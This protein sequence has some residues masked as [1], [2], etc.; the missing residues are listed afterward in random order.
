MLPCA[1]FFLLSLVHSSYGRD[2]ADD[3]EAINLINKYFNT[4]DH[5]NPPLYLCNEAQSF[6]YRLPKQL[7]CPLLKLDKPSKVI[8]ITTWFNDISQNTIDGI[9][10]Y[11]TMTHAR[12]SHFFFGGYSEANIVVDMPV[13]SDECRL[14]A[15]RQ[16]TPTDLPMNRLHDNH[17]TSGIDTNVEYSW[18]NTNYKATQNWFYSTITI[19][20]N[21]VDQTIITPITTTE[22]CSIFENKCTA[23]GQGI[24][25]WEGDEFQ[26]CRL[27]KGESSKCIFSDNSRISCPELQISINAIGT[28]EI[29]FINVGAS[30]QGILYSTDVKGSIS[31]LIASTEEIM[32]KIIKSK[33]TRK[34]RGVGLQN[35]LNDTETTDEVEEE[36]PPPLIEMP[37]PNKPTTVILPKLE[38]IPAYVEYDDDSEYPT[39]KKD[40]SRNVHSTTIPTTQPTTTTTTKTTENEVIPKWRPNEQ[41]TPSHLKPITKS[42]PLITALGRPLQSESNIKKTEGELNYKIPS[43]GTSTT[44]ENYQQTQ[45]VKVFTDAQVNARLQYL[46][47]IVNKNIDYAIQLVHSTVCNQMQLMLNLLRALAEQSPNVLIRTLLSDGRYSG[48]LSGDTLM[49]SKCTPIHQ[50]VFVMPNETTCTAEFPVKY[51]YNNEQYLGF[52]RPLSHELVYEPE[53]TTCPRQNFYFDTGDE[54]LLLNNRTTMT[55][56][57]PYLQLPSETDPDRKPVDIA[58]SSTGHVNLN[59]MDKSNDFY[60]FEKQATNPNKIDAILKS[61]NQGIPLTSQQ[62]GVSEALRQLTLEPIYDFATTAFL[63][64]VIIVVILITIRICCCCRES[65]WKALTKCCKFTCCTLFRLFFKKRPTVTPSIEETEE[66]EPIFEEPTPKLKQ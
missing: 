28:T 8:G 35:I 38:D 54:V 7:N 66:E 1:V 47:E 23:V 56:N 41:H 58:F 30:T 63:I 60:K 15:K 26:T 24:I 33:N 2:V 51:M 44:D 43:N 36:L 65:I 10:C 37:K 5:K 4:L 59:R 34:P 62:L 45:T 57:M 27:Q 16:L 32:A 52:L 6:A 21:N 55:S 11:S 40:L 3:P 39:T 61:K 17:F 19:S 64:V 22:T 20:S 31:P 18:P 49:I 14:M 25:V 13:S 46:S 50:Y 9:H 53:Y 29:C 42:N 48:I 12:K